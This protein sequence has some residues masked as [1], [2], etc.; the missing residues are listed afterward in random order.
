MTTTA[1]RHPARRCTRA[2]GQ[3]LLEMALVAPILIVLLLAGAQVGQIAYSLVSLD[4]ATREGAR[5]GVTAPNAALKSGGVVWYA[6]STT[7]HQCN[8]TDYND[9]SGNGNPI[10]IAVLN[11]AGYLNQ[12][13]FTSSPGCPLACVTIQVIPPGG[14]SERPLSGHS[15]KLLSATSSPCNNGNQATVQGTVFGIPNGMA[16]TVADSSGDTQSGVTGAYTMCVAATGTTTSQVITAQVGPVSCNGY[17]GSIGPFTVAH[18]ITYSG[19]G[20]GDITVTAEPACA[21]PT[22]TATPG[23]TASPSPSPTPTAG[24]TPTPT[25]GPGAGCSGQTVPDSYY[26]TVKV[27]YPVPIF[28]PFI[29]AVFQTQSGVRQISTSVTDAIEPC[30]ITGGA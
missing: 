15:A 2:R 12:S 20:Q 14:L 26:I 28:V 3:A 27:S 16:A 7:T 5:A 22:P 29:G 18:G 24:P 21:T 10:C 1:P 13:S 8:A 19:S 9:L 17:S 11:A 23:P 25:A 4:S 6:G 30:T